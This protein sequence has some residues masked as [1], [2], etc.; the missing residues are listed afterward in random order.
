MAANPSSQLCR[1]WW[2]KESTIATTV[3]TRLL[4]LQDLNEKYSYVKR[5]CN[6][7]LLH[8]EDP[9][10]LFL[11]EAYYILA[12]ISH[13]SLHCQ[14]NL[15]LDTNLHVHVLIVLKVSEINGFPLTTT[16]YFCQVKRCLQEDQLALLGK[17]LNYIEPA[18]C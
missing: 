3:A 2:Q 14:R 18:A 10:T 4:N 17:L 11:K 5:S 8:E 13:I 12:F 16:I 7:F 6:S 1:A 9:D 15:V